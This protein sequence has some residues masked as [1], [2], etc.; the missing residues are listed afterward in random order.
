MFSLTKRLSIVVGTVCLGLALA[1]P[2]NPVAQAGGRKAPP[3]NAAESKNMRLVGHN[4]LQARS[5]Y[6]GHVQEQNG[7][8]IAYVGHHGGSAFN[9]L[10]GMDEDNGASIVDVTD[11]KRP[12]YL[13]HLK[14][15][16][17][18]NQSR[19][20][21]TC[22]GNDLSGPGT[23]GKFYLHREVGGQADL[24]EV[25]DVTDPEN[26]EFVAHIQ[27]ADGTHKN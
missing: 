26:P 27:Q 21:Q 22:D 15:T 12:V 16:P 20:L 5:A 23:D 25:W 24:H 19:N 7:R 4:D 14:P 13:H 17:P 11:P 3:G 1:A 9:P 2:M 6:K 8:F 18:G 10:T